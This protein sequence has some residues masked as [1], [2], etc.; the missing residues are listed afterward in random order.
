MEIDAKHSQ[1]VE[2]LK[3]LLQEVIVAYCIFLFDDR[4]FV[5]SFL[6]AFLRP[7]T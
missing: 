4:R 7:F 1:E 6:Y 3:R 2:S 5:E